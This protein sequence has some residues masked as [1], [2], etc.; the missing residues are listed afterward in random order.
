ML[1]MPMHELHNWLI[2]LGLVF[3]CYLSFV[4]VKN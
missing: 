3:A 1:G 4:I 2:M